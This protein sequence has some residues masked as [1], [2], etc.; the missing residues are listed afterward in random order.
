MI[1]AAILLTFAAASCGGDDDGATPAPGGSQTATAEPSASASPTT[2]PTRS[3]APT[4]T[5]T[6]TQMVRGEDRQL[7]D[8]SVLVKTGCWGCDVPD[9]GLFRAWGLGDSGAGYD[10]LLRGS[11]APGSPVTD[12]DG[13]TLANGMIRDIV[14]TSDTSVIAVT[15]CIQGICTA[16]Q[17]NGFDATSISVTFRSQDGGVTW[18]EIDRRGPAAVA[19]GVMQNGQVLIVNTLDESGA[20][21]EYVLMPSSERITPPEHVLRPLVASDAVVWVTPDK[22]LIRTDGSVVATLPLGPGD[23]SYPIS[24]VGSV[25]DKGSAL[26]SWYE[27]DD[28]QQGFPHIAS[29]DNLAGDYST[30]RLVYLGG[31]IPKDLLAVISIEAGLD[32]PYPALLDMATGQYNVITNPFQGGASVDADTGRTIVAGVRNGP[33]QLVKGT[34][35]CLNIRAEPSLSGQVL[36]CAAEG[37]LL[38]DLGETATGDGI[39]WARVMTPAGTQGWSSTTYLQPQN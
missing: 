36:T 14:A 12:W 5:P 20:N 30:D 28:T 38:Y 21:V 29:L 11:Y 8:L 37:V 26:V 32:H 24:I 22:T 35:S 23:I 15:I 16:D 10:W 13:T 7:G 27:I 1:S 9:S 18:Q 3:P 4:A 6:G 39:G 25:G 17:L 31:W 2:A 19:V 34:G 33:F